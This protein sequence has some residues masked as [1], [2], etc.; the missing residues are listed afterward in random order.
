[1]QCVLMR[2]LV[3]DLNL[4]PEI[5]VCPTSKS[6]CLSSYTHRNNHLL[7]IKNHLHLLLSFPPFSPRRRRPGHE[8]SQRLLGR[9]G[10]SCNLSFS[11]GDSLKFFVSALRAFTH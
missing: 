9:A 4:L 2:R 8:Q 5:V 6:E 11:R 3:E 1:M 7:T 10:M